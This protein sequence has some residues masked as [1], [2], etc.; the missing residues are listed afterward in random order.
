MDDNIRKKDIQNL[1]EMTKQL[2][3][4]L[5]RSVVEITNKIDTTSSNIISVIF[6]ESKKIREEIGYQ[7]ILIKTITDNLDELQFDEN[8]GLST[9]IEFSIGA[10]ILGT[11]AKWAINID[12]TKIDYE[13]ITSR[14]QQSTKV[15]NNI[16]EKIL[17]KIKKY[18]N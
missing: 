2:Q 9:N 4:S 3:S 11:G 12:P 16:K 14:I 18:F 6:S 7:N 5:R 15:P 17:K 1:N 13:E 10:E 8:I